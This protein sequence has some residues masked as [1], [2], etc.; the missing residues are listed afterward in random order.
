VITRLD[1]LLSAYGAAEV[2][3]RAVID[4]LVARNGI[5]QG[6]LADLIEAGD[7]AGGLDTIA[8][9]ANGSALP[10]SVDAATLAEQAGLAPRVA[11][12]PARPADPLPPRNATATKLGARAAREAGPTRA[13][14]DPAIRLARLIDQQEERI[15]GIFNTAVAAMKDSLDLDELAD[16]L[17]RGRPDEAIEKLMRVADDLGA[18]SNFAFITSGQSTAD[19]IAGAGVGRAVFDHVNTNAVAAMQANRLSMIAEFTAEQRRATSAALISGVE[20]GA[21]PR[22]QARDFRDSVGL[23]EKQWEHVAN[24]RAKLERV[25]T[26]S[27]SQ[28]A[29]L[30]NAL[31]NKGSD[32]VIRR[33]VKQGRP[34]DPERIDKMATAYANRYIKYRAEVIG[35]TEAMRAV[36]EGNE[37]GWRQ[38]IA[39]GVVEARDL[40]RKWVTRLDGRERSTHLLL[41][42][43]TRDWGEPWQTKHGPI[44]YPGDPDAPASEVVQCRCHLT[45]RIRRK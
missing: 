28:L 2:L 36:N 24:Y 18:A 22:E 20:R 3:V 9:A 7:L 26:G 29:A 25:G 11:P 14:E 44:R 38:A 10:I 32:S 6:A 30:D 40:T 37:E 21:N 39:D 23:T 12:T 8:T 19:F 41:N 27:R 5:N 42:G 16:L 1:Q 33:A 13:V 31:R 15:A 4:L 17:A 34:L 45:T 35:R 43:Q